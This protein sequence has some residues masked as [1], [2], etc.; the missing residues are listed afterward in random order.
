MC[1]QD[2]KV[3]IRKKV[4]YEEDE[5]DQ[6]KENADSA[7]YRNGGDGSNSDGG[8]CGDSTDKADRKSIF[9]GNG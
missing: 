9:R 6:I 7:A 1:G 2:T 8:V 3:S 5:V 4:Q